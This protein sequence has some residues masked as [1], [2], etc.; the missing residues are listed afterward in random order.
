MKPTPITFQNISIF[1]K[2]FKPGIQH[3]NCG[4]GFIVR[5]N[6]VDGDGHIAITETNAMKNRKLSQLLKSYI[7]DYIYYIWYHNKKHP[8]FAEFMPEGKSKATG[9]TNVV[10]KAI[11]QTDCHIFTKVQLI[12]FINTLVSKKDIVVPFRCEKCVKVPSIT[13]VQRSFPIAPVN[14][15]SSGVK[16]NVSTNA[17]NSNTGNTPVNSTVNATVPEVLKTN[18]KVVGNSPTVAVEKVE[19]NA[20]KNADVKF[21]IKLVRKKI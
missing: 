14:A 10:C 8:V 18:V 3:V 12:S 20:I 15:N 1:G 13:K 6:F 4:I 16:P 17:I 11:G 21:G 9:F 19:G 5:S 2:N 7:W